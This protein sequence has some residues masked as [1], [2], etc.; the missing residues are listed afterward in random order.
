MKETYSV[1][2]IDSNGEYSRLIKE[3]DSLSWAKKRARKEADDEWS[4]GVRYVVSSGTKGRGASLMEDKRAS[5]V[6]MNGIE[7]GGNGVYEV[8]A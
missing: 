6:G 8:D 1:W 4:S 2:K 5:A 7:Y 3:Y